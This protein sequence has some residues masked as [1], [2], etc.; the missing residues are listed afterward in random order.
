MLE[1]GKNFK[2]TL[3]ETCLTCNKTDNEQHRLTEC[4]KW[5]NESNQETAEGIVFN[6]IYSQDDQTLKRIIIQIQN[7]WELRYGNGKMKK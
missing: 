5:T 1:C 2:G 6:D 4:A 3:N 7:L